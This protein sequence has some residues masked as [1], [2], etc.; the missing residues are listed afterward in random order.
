MTDTVRRISV[1]LS[2]C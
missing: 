2:N 1:M